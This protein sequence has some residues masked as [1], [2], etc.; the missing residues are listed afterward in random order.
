MLIGGKRISD[1]CQPFYNTNNDIW[2]KPQNYNGLKLYPINL[3]DIETIS[4]MNYLLSH[5]PKNIQ[6]REIRGVSY[7]KYITQVFPI[8]VHRENENI[9]INE[10]FI[11]F[12]EKITQLKVELKLIPMPHIKYI[13]D[14]QKLKD[15]YLQIIFKDNEKEFVF[16]ESDFEIIREMILIQ[17]GTSLDYIESYDPILEENL[18]FINREFKDITFEEQLFS[19]C[20]YLKCPVNIFEKYTWYQFKKHFSRMEIMLDYEIYKPLIESGQIELKRGKLKHW[21]EHIQYQG[22]YESILIGKDNFVQNNEFI[23]HM[24]QK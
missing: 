2:G 17:N 8:I 10:I 22:R 13:Q 24:Q 5:N 15:F 20:S 16:M 12:L 1:I 9:N 11:N 19:F 23:K 6:D 4:N 7:L 18:D 3:C 14:V 21:L